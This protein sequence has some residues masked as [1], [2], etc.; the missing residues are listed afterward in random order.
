MSL[1]TTALF[2]SL[3]LW[4]RLLSRWRREAVR[5]PAMAAARQEKRSPLI[6]AQEIT[7]SDKPCQENPG[8]A[9]GGRLH[10]PI[11][12]RNPEITEP[13]ASEVKGFYWIERNESQNPNAQSG[14]RLQSKLKE[15]E[16]VISLLTTGVKLI[17]NLVT[18]VE[19][20]FKKPSEQKGLTIFPANTA[21]RCI[22]ARDSM[23]A[24][25][26]MSRSVETCIRG[27]QN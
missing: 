25:F 8:Q 5:L 27:C 4:C 6:S 11:S 14:D 9:S 15:D 7:Q 16:D 26:R 19:E 22:L 2:L 1:F 10:F 23:R 3:P 20:N 18:K 17:P 13:E 21:T 12:T 24:S